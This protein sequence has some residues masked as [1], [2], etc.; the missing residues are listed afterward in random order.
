M[1]KE[2]SEFLALLNAEFSNESMPEAS[3]VIG[4]SIEDMQVDGYFRDKKWTEIT[5]DWLNNYDGDS[6][7]CLWFMKPE[8]FRYYLPAYLKIAL[9]H[10]QTSNTIPDTVV[11][12]LM[13]TALDRDSRFFGV[14]DELNLNQKK[15]VA[16]FLDLMSKE[17][18]H[19]YRPD[20]A[21][22]A[23]DEYWGRF[24]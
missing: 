24:L 18:W 23:L 15:I 19:L 14:L 5:L 13:Q 6:S 11:N 16:R 1:K 20:S 4:N 8:A 17:Y 2:F 7:A 21:K 22:V 10:Y 12:I 9:I 3:I